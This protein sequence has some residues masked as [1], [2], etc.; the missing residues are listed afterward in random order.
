MKYR[1]EAELV[2]ALQAKCRVAGGVRAYARNVGLDNGL[3][4]NILNGKRTMT[5]QVANALGYEPIT[6]YQVVP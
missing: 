6:M 4:S 5:V 1:S 2:T 3:L